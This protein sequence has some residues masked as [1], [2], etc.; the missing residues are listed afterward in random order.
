MTERLNWTDWRGKTSISRTYWPWRHYFVGIKGSSNPGFM[1][2]GP[3]HH[4]S[5]MSRTSYLTPTSLSFLTCK[6]GPKLG[7]NPRGWL[8]E[9]SEIWLFTKLL[10][11]FGERNG[12][13]LQYSCLRGAW[14]ATWS[15]G[16]QRVGRDWATN[17]TTTINFIITAC[18]CVLSHFSCVWLCNSMDCSPPGSSIPDISRQEYWSGLPWPP[19]G[20][21]PHP[22]IK[23]MSL[24]SPALAGGFFTTGYLGIPDHYYSYYPYSNCPN[25]IQMDKL[26]CFKIFFL[27]LPLK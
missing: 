15:M 23:P 4:L 26:F 16:S 18:C 14:W 9:L 8:W 19:P 1:L 3:G 11:L 13:P 22:G 2:P 17:T 25:R 27:S 5:L 24:M 20:D 10:L 12:K 7:P 6:M 21:L